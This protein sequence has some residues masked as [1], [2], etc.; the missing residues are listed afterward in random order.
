MELKDKVV[1][2]TGSSSGI[3]EATAY[4]F[5]KEGAKIIINSKTNTVGGKKVAKKIVEDGGNAIYLQA[6][7]SDPKQVKKLFKA[8]IKKY[9]TI[10]ILINNAGI[11]RTLDFFSSK[12]DEWIQE[13]NDNFFG[14]VLCSQEAA[15]I[16]KKKGEG[17]ILNTASI[18]GLEHTGREGIMAYSAAKAA[19]VN[20]T[21]TLAKLLAPRIQVN[22]IAP[23]FVYTPNYDPLPK[24]LKN[25]FIDNT[26][27]KRWIKVDEIARAFVFLAKAEA[28]TGEVMVVDAG[29]TLKDG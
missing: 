9:K 5:A 19:V 27:L 23:G 20:F 16:M 18:R 1:L 11:T 8:I 7:V 24:E 22:A 25:K 4:L 29:F 26:L 17:K 6:D 28:I 10:D 13:F 15:K 21:K 14:T 12:K 3:G 2:I